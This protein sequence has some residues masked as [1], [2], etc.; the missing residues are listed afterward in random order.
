MFVISTCG[1]IGN[2]NDAVKCELPIGEN[3]V[4]WLRISACTR[5]SVKNKG[6]KF[7][8]YNHCGWRTWTYGPA[9]VQIDKLVV[10]CRSLVHAD[11]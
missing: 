3:L 1:K 7:A 4:K 9:W 10:H 5:K 8:A 6:P 2:C 11:H